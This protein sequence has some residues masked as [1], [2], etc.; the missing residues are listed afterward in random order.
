MAACCCN[1]R[2]SCTTLAVVLS[3]IVGVVAAFLQ[4]TAAVTVTAVALWVTFG[5]AVGYP[6]VI[7]LGA[8]LAKREEAPAC[9]C[10]ALVTQLIASI[11][12]VLFS[13]I[14][15]AV[16]FPATSVL[17]AI[18]VGLWVFSFALAVSSA[19]CVVRCYIGCEE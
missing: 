5:I 8:A 1:N 17:G 18:V 7:L 14:L 19:A 10:A 13:T 12:T 15:L 9:C 11:G 4:I 2:W 6:L 3:A 16:T